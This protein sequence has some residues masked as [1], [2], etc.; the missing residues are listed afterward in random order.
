MKQSEYEDYNEEERE[1]LNADY[2][3]EMTGELGWEIKRERSN[4]LCWTRPGLLGVLKRSVIEGHVTHRLQVLSKINLSECDAT[5]T[6]IF[7]ELASTSLL[8]K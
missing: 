1:N 7:S 6:S 4:L 8:N 2:K 3:R 5:N